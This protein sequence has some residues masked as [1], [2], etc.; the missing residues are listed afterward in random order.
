MGAKGNMAQTKRE[1]RPVKPARRHPACT[2]VRDLDAAT[3]LVD[4]RRNRFLAPF[5]GR[6]CGVTEAAREAGASRSLASYWV[7]RF[8]A[9]GLLAPAGTGGSR[10]RAYRST[11]DSFTVSL[12]DMPDLPDHIVLGA[13]M[14]ASFDRIKT[15]LVRSARRHA[16]RWE[17]RIERTP[18]GVR[19]TLQPREG[20]LQDAP[21]VNERAGLDL[22]PA[23]AA[24]LRAEMHALMQRYTQRSQAGPGRERVIVW[25]LAVEQ[26]GH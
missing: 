3:L 20:R 15:A 17:F 26:G 16:S 1:K 14:D 6:D 4:A 2:E 23:D 12:D 7:A 5:I 10:H 11:A 9:A 8:C 24:A 21:L 25:M 13:Q 18:Q 19:Q 22:G